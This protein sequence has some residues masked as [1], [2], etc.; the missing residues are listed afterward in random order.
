MLE[1]RSAPDHRADGRARQVENSPWRAAQALCLP[2]GPQ[3]G[4][5]DCRQ[6][7]SHR[8]LAG[9]S[10]LSCPHPGSRVLSAQ[11][12]RRDR[13]LWEACGGLLGPWSFS[14][15][16]AL[17]GGGRASSLPSPGQVSGP[18]TLVEGWGLQLS[19]WSGGQSSGR[20]RGVDVP[21][22]APARCQPPPG[23]LGR[24][25]SGS[26]LSVFLWDCWAL[27]LEGHEATPTRPGKYRLCRPVGFG[28]GGQDTSQVPCAGSQGGGP[29]TTAYSWPPFLLACLPEGP[30][31]SLELLS[32][33]F[34]HKH[35]YVAGRF[36][37]ALEA[38]ET[39]LAFP[40]FVASQSLTSLP[41]GGPGRP[42]VPGAVGSRPTGRLPRGHDPLTVRHRRHGW[43]AWSVW[44]EEVLEIRQGM[45]PTP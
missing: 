6:P 31:Q 19:A 29:C 34:T 37:G 41:L 20:C 11:A 38:E 39:P 45:T 27:L 8:E 7:G 30:S 26:G 28:A 15:V 13:K 18:G 42:A 22:S 10:Q 43:G 12:G 1:T 3:P 35:F 21:V 17:G 9:A 4:L 23:D 14:A 5:G 25:L 40:G 24:A 16:A 33:M 32:G 44:A 2:G 36:S